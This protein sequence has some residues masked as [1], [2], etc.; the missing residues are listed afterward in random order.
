MSSTIDRKVVEMRFDNSDFE[1]NVSITLNSLKQ[2]Q[3]SLNMTESCKSL[4]SLESTVNGIDVSG[5]NGAIS[6]IE[7]RFSNLGIIGM[8]VIQ[9]LT[10]TAINSAKKVLSAVVGA[11]KQGGITRATNIENAKFQLAGLGIAWK[12][13]S[14][15]IDYGVKD[16]A[17]S[18]DAAAKAASSL[19]ASG[20]Q[21]GDSMK[22]SLRGI[23]G[24]AAMTN[25]SY[26]EISSIFTTVAGQGKLMTMQLRQL[27]MRGLNVAAIMG[28]QL[29]KTEAEIR[30]MVTKGTIDFATFSK[31]MDDAFGAHAK[32]A[33]KTLNG[34]LS[35]VKSALA[36]IGAEFVQPII[37]NEGP[38]VQ[39]LNALRVKINEVKDAIIPFAKDTTTAINNL[40]SNI[41]KKIEDADL[42]NS[43]KIFNNIV[44]V[45]K[46]TLRGLYNILKII[47][48]TF[49]DVFPE[50]ASNGILAF[51]EKL[52]DFTSNIKMSKDTTEKLKN[53]FRGF[54]SLLDI[55]KQLLENLEKPLSVVLKIGVSLGRV[56]LTVTSSLGAW[57]TKIDQAI[58][59]VGFF[60]SIFSSFDADTSGFDKFVN[61]VSDKISPLELLFLGLSKI[62]QGV[63][64]A[65][66]KI[67]V[68][69][70][71]AS[72]IVLKIFSN[73]FSGLKEAMGG[74]N[75]S[76]AIKLVNSGF[77][78]VVLYKLKDL[79]GTLTASINNLKPFGETVRNTINTLK[80]ALFEL[81]K[82]LKTDSLKNV[83]S[84]VLELAVAVLILSSVDD[85]KLATSLGA[86]TG[87]LIE[88][89]TAMK[90]MDKISGKGI[91]ETY[92]ITNIIIKMAESILILAVAVK[93]LASVPFDSMMGAMLGITILLGEMVGVAFIFSKFESNFK[94]AA[95]SM[96]LMA[97]AINLLV[98]PVTKLASLEFEAMMQGLLGVT[99]LL[100][101]MI[102]VA[103]IFSKFESSFRK[104]A[105]SMI[106]MAVAIKTLIGPVVTLAS[107]DFLAMMQGLLG[108]TILIGVL[109]GASALMSKVAPMMIVGSAGLLLM[110][111]AMLA[112]IPTLKTLESMSGGDLAKVIAGIGFLL[113]TLAGGLTAMIVAL[114]GAAALMVAAKALL[115]L[116]GVL[117]V[118][119]AIPFLDLLK[120]LGMMAST[121]LSISVVGTIC[122]VL[123]PLLIAFGV[124]LMTVSVACG[125]MAAA[126]TALSISGVAGITALKIVLSG[127]ITMIPDICKALGESIIGL[128]DVL[129]KVTP[130]IMEL[131][132]KI[133]I[134]IC[135]TIIQ[136]C[137]KISK[138]L[139]AV[140]FMAC[141]VL[142]E[143]VPKIINT[144]IA[145]LLAFLHGIADNIGEVVTTAIEIIVNLLNGIAKKIPDVIAAGVN[146]AMSFIEGIVM[147]IPII[148]DRAGKL[149]VSFL[150]GLAD[151]IRKNA[152][153]IHNAA[154]N[155]INAFFEAMLT[156]IA[157]KEGAS[158]FKN[159]GKNIIDGLKNGIKKSI[160]KI[161][162]IAKDIGSSLLNGVKSFL[163]I[164]SPSREF[165]KIGMYSDEG[166]AG[167]LKKYAGAVVDAAKNVASG[168]I[169]TIDNGLSG[170]SNLISDALEGGPTI[171]PVLDLSDIESG[172]RQINGMFSARQAVAL[173]SS[174]TIGIQ[175][176]GSG[177]VINMTINGAQG[178][179]VNQ[180][181]DLV[182]ERINNS[183]QRRNN[184][185]R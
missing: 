10:N 162:D 39:M 25:S 88:M 177:Y 173:A 61:N 112:L 165:M 143:C 146:V 179:D 15:D 36:R 142:L 145:L 58:E 136:A 30:D 49:K 41:T 62:I 138:A 16:T 13:I 175:N 106:L 79:I 158:K 103:F 70:G 161:K 151:S 8:T 75:A 26:E 32:D 6:T 66:S 121:F 5:L 94:K 19:V 31:A 56:F 119:A 73:L 74:S 105:T 17:Y 65:I 37:E 153:D 148:V 51:T 35:N 144:G 140:V 137:P 12:D 157:G 46:N 27:E 127:F 131:I 29:G 117:T 92:S 125:I 118:L 160:S 113:L 166:L 23:S 60:K 111:V 68:V 63:G 164:K 89:M 43:F 55:G 86:V 176:G 168:A 20:I 133:I 183:I 11:I 98:K 64:F 67:S 169:N 33:N 72:D 132:L 185:W 120:A 171:R 7:S 182:S 130:K 135:D 167:G 93:V 45:L 81:E 42:T 24:V 1:K 124:A 156:V 59:K 71:K 110:S 80:G 96:I 139:I 54:F 159:I 174:G 76:E 57:I 134:G 22:T 129:I 78:A 154:K 28:Q 9:N 114:P 180:L 40:F 4:K 149:I 52:K 87:L 97:V 122:G 95:T 50:S 38:L 34:T 90:A 123:S 21:L 102:G 147:Q 83:A 108:V 116:T 3:N 109:V 128:C 82:N 101:E 163:G 47:G 100:G 181:A 18:M 53:T 170:M 91:K 48:S 107:L 184:V 2:L 69:I 84:A 126:M 115:V 141:D 44:D 85:K 178:Q 77:L 172:A 14:E 150:N 152:E 104:A 155:F 99:I